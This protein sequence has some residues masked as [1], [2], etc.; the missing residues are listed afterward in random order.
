MS[1]T[2]PTNLVKRWTAVAGHGEGKSRWVDPAGAMRALDALNHLQGKPGVLVLDD[3]AGFTDGSHGEWR[4]RM[5]ALGEFFE[6]SCPVLPVHKRHAEKGSNA[7]DLLSIVKDEIR[8]LR[9]PLAAV[10]DMQWQFC[11]EKGKEPWFGL[12]LIRLIKRAKPSLPIFVWSPIQDKH[13]L[14]RAMQLGAS[15]CF[16]KPEALRFNH[17]LPSDW[18]PDPYNE[19]DAGKLW[20]RLLEWEMARYQCPPV[21]AGDGDFILAETPET[22]ACRKRFLKD[23]GLSDSELLAKPEPPV[24]RLLRALVPDAVGVEILRFFG[25]GQSGLERPFVAR[26]RTANG[27]WLRP[28]QIK[29]SRNWRALSRESKGYR[30][31]F[32]GCLGPSVAHVLTGPYRLEEWCGMSQSFAAPEEAIRDISSKSTRSFES[33][34]RKK[35]PDAAQCRMLV[36]EVFDGVLDPLY[37]DNLAKRPKSVLKAYDRVS[38][39]HLE[40]PFVPGQPEPAVAGSNEAGA[41]DLDPKQLSRKSSRAR[42]EAAYRAWRKVEKWWNAPESDKFTIRGMVIESLEIN[43]ENPLKSRL[44]LLDPTIGIKIDLYANTPPLA[45]LWGSLEKCPIKLVGMPVSFAIEKA[46]TKGEN[47]QGNGNGIWRYLFTGWTDSVKKLLEENGLLQSDVNQEAWKRVEELFHP[48]HPIDWSEDFH[49]G[50]THGDLNLG[51]ILLHQKGD[52]LFPWLIDFDKAADERPVVFDLAKLEI[53]AY[54]KI[55]QELF[56]ELLEMGCVSKD[57][58]LRDLI[59]HFEHALGTKGI[60]GSGHLWERFRGRRAVPDSLKSRFSGLF[61]YLRQVHKRVED[62]G[63]TGREF[64]IGRAVYSLCCLKF[65]HLYKCGVHP[66]APFPAKVM[67]WKLEALLD[68]LD[69]D[70]GI[71]STGPV[72]GASQS[73]QQK[74]IFAVVSAIREARLGGDTR[75]LGE[76]LAPIVAKSE[77]EFESLGLLPLYKDARNWELLFR[78]LRD[79]QYPAGTDGFANCFGMRGTLELRKSPPNWPSSQKRWCLRHKTQAQRCLKSEPNGIMLLRAVSATFTPQQKCSSIW[80]P[81]GKSSSSKSPPAGIREEPSTFSNRPAFLSARVPR[82]LNMS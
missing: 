62:L 60:A 13:V 21:G 38:P 70:N 34:L 59:R 15:S 74:A 46:S 63:L 53:E 81:R 68:M 29:L 76:V 66:N 48:S 71:V 14:Q 31:V 58:E 7:D 37:K 65:K 32:A 43:E 69:A 20:F 5:E 40:L 51:N 61:A 23:F 6:V 44:R 17:D 26:G 75:S 67:L 1:K 42:R 10:V 45:Q 52:G 79:K 16:D 18:K 80:Q 39:P 78:L 47:K 36:D 4:K 77:G 50:P 11:D 73:V 12:E 3:L 41:I 72:S 25:E 30:D 19:L 55:A 33:W 57:A 49:I 64:L 28:V 2:M 54:H 8:R 27:R 9:R 22:L 56:W 35:L 82:Q 24:E